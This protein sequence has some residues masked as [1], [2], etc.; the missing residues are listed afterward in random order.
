MGE[1]HG[2]AMPNSLR[3]V[4]NP[5]ERGEPQAGACKNSPMAAKLVPMFFS[6]SRPL[7]AVMLGFGALGEQKSYVLF[8]RLYVLANRNKDIPNRISN[9]NGCPPQPSSIFIIPS[10]SLY[11]PAE[12]FSDTL[13]M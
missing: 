9:T 8:K 10:P 12:E 11:L 4:A 1:P 7:N 3:S 6:G 5:R 2:L 13:S